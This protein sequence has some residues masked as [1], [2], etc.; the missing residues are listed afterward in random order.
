[1]NSV[2]IEMYKEAGARIFTDRDTGIRARRELELDKLEKVG[3]IVVLLPEDTWGVNPSFFGGM[4][5]TSIKNMGEQFR[6]N[7]VFQYSNGNE[8]KDSL[9]ENIENDYDY[10][11]RGLS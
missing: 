4:F 8:L 1:M 11:M 6:Q 10:V 7:Y 9:K 2:N 5:E 3:K